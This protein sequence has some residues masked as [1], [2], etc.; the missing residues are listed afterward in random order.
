MRTLAIYSLQEYG[1]FSLSRTSIA[2]FAV[3]PSFASKINEQSGWTS[4]IAFRTSI[5]E[6]KFFPTLSFR[7]WNPCPRYFAANWA[8]SFGVTIGIWIGKHQDK[9]LVM[10][11]K[12]FQE[13]VQ[14]GN[15]TV[16]SV[17][18]LSD[19]PPNNLHRGMRMLLAT[20]S[21]SAISTPALALNGKGYNQIQP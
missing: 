20:A 5:S 12:S 9:I 17:V 11:F 13:S 6:F 18:T 10:V 7:V 1:P 16:M 8:A 21:I 14:W 2:W 15:R 4:R 19:A 3:Y